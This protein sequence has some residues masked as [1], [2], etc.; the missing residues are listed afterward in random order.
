LHFSGSL[1][2]HLRGLIDDE[3][4]RGKYIVENVAKRTECHSP[5]DQNGENG[6]NGKGLSLCGAKLVFAPITP[7]ASWA[8]SAPN[9][10][11]IGGYNEESAVTLFSSGIAKNYGRLAPPMPTYNMTE[12]DARAVYKYLKSLEH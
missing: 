5:R 3:I 2:W 10:R 4:A 1:P 12:D 8:E 9:I 11:G 7:N 6:K